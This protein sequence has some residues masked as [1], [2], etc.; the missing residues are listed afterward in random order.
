MKSKKELQQIAKCIAQLETK[1]MR[2]DK[3]AESEIERISCS[4]TMEE[5][6]QIDE[7]LV[8]ELKNF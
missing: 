3:K 2:G 1:V 7:I 8:D 4:L 5:M 6:L